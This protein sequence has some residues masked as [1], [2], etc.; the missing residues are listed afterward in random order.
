[1]CD[2]K[3]LVAS[4]D[5]AAIN[6]LLTKSYYNTY[7]TKTGQDA[8]AYL[9][10]NTPELMILDAHLAD[11]DGTSISYR[12]KR[13]ARLRDIPVIVLVNNFDFKMRSAADLSNADQIILKPYTGRFLREAVRDWL[14][15]SLVNTIENSQP[16]INY[17]H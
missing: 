7:A 2:S 10:S 9:R 14:E 4:P 11:I 8:L 15:P 1:M 16:S 13:L 17:S 5:A 12:V 6:T 3:I